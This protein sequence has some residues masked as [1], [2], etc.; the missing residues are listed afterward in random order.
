MIVYYGDHKYQTEGKKDKLWREVFTFKI[1]H[2]E[3]KPIIVEL[4]MKSRSIWSTKKIIGR[5]EIDILSS[6][7]NKVILTDGEKKSSI[8]YFKLKLLWAG[9][10]YDRE[11]IYLSNNIPNIKIC[12][13][14]K[15]FIYSI[16]ERLVLIF[17]LASGLSLPLLIIFIT[18]Y[19]SFCYSYRVSSSILLFFYFTF[20]FLRFVFVFTYVY[21][22]FCVFLWRFVAVALLV[23]N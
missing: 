3:I 23:P 16:L 8:V 13:L 18:L 14:L 17:P 4:E 9:W 6:G 11:V 5:G 7:E 21:F 15:G 20:Y 22:R 12:L 1:D 19:L 2:T 10:A